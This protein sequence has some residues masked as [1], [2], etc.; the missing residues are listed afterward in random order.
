M[1]GIQPCRQLTITTHV[2]NYPGY[3]EGI[4]RPEII[5][6]FEKQAKRMGAESVVGKQ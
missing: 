5:L 3:A 4:Q 2:E 1:S 6:H